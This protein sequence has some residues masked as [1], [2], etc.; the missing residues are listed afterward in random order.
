MWHPSDHWVV[1]H[2]PQLPHQKSWANWF[3]IRFESGMSQWTLHLLIGEDL[4]FVGNRDDL[5]GIV[6]DDGSQV[7]FT[8][9]TEWRRATDLFNSVSRQA[10]DDLWVTFAVQPLADG[11]HADRATALIREHGF[12]IL[13]DV[14]D[15][16]QIAALLGGCEELEA[17]LVRM[18][19]YPEV[20]ISWVRL[21]YVPHMYIK[22][23]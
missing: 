4:E 20:V 8:S 13:P 22:A 6:D 21:H 23:G 17:E 5:I 15:S 18:D 19:R 2:G 10:L 14:L 9:G 1:A 16:Q 7:V 12:V 3:C 11:S